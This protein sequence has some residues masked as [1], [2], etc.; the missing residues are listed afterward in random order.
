[1]RARE[2]YGQGVADKAAVTLP[3]PGSDIT[4]PP[5]RKGRPR[6]RDSA[7]TRD[8]LL[9]AARDR[10]IS[11]GYAA[12]T[13]KTIAEAAGITPGAIYH[14]V[15]SKADLY[16]AVYDEVF[17]QVYSE[18][19][20]VAA[21]E[22][23][24]V[25]QFSAMLDATV[26]LNQHD[27]SLANFVVG[28]SREAQRHPELVDRLMP[29]QRRHRRVLRRLVS[30]AVERGELAADIDQRAVADVL[31]SQLSGIVRLS[32]SLADPAR[33][34]SAVDISKQLLAG[35]LLQNPHERF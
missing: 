3:Q 22:T 12:T 25:G 11:D 10:F 34:K 35:S 26:S 30:D 7:D 27:P 5:R 2:D 20:R 18:Y 21:T 1:M 4:S 33:F 13:N 16:V 23:T 19:E 14:Y 24:L 28:V 9:R 17:D 15:S 32:T 29:L 31:N 6:D 8:R